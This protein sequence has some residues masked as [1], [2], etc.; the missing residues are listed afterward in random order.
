[1]KQRGFEIA[2]G[3]EDKDI[4]LPVRST[5]N[6][7]AYD[8]EAATD[9]TIPPF[10]PGM[11]PTLVPTGLKA[12]CQPDE[13]YFILNRSSG[14]GKGVFLSNGV[15][16]I[17]ADYYENPENDGHFYVLVF[18]TLD[19]D[20]KIKKHDRI[21]QVV[22]QKFLLTDD[23]QAVGIRKGGFGSTDQ[24]KLTVIYDVD[25]VLWPCTENVFHKLGINPNRQTNFRIRED[26]AFSADEQDRII[27]AFCDEQSFQNMDFYDGADKILEV[28]D[29]GAEVQINSNSFSEKIRAAKRRQLTELFPNLRAEQLRLNLVGT[30]A[31]HKRISADVFAFVDDSPYNVAGSQAK[32]NFM[33][34]RPWNTTEEMQKI[35]CEHEKIYLGDIKQ[36]LG[37]LVNDSQCYVVPVNDLTEARELIYQ[38]IKLKQEG[39]KHEQE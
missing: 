9:I 10:H 33:P 14:A 28:E 20:L 4:H 27:S 16:L 35:A 37:E 23:D 24:P 31:N 26:K 39:V 8:I 34:K 25:D 7:A 15:G 6:A 29:L 38:A 21:A 12:Y 2:R 36:R 17:D 3:W 19:H 18:N 1:M 13:C 22:F 5:A 30:N 32:F 11:K